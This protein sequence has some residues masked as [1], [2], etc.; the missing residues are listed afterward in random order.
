MRFAQVYYALGFWVVLGLIVFFIFALKDKKAT[1]QRFAQD[2]LLGEI[3]SSFDY[4]KQRLRL[5]LI[6]LVLIFSILALMRPQW[7]FQWQEVKRRGLDILIAIDTSKSMLASDVKPNRLE[8]S[9]LAVKDLIKKLQGDRIGLI[10]FSGTAFLQ[11]PLTVDYN[12]FLLALDDLGVDTI[13]QGGTSISWAVKEALKSFEGEEK[14]YK[15]LVIITDGEDHEGGAVR[16]AQAANKENVK[17]FSI[18]IGTS[19]GELIQVADARGSREFLKDKDGN[20]VKSRLNEG[21]LKQIA[22]TTGG[23][24]VRSSGAEFGLDLIY[25][26]KI[27]KMEKR[28]IK[29]QMAKFYHERFQIP[30]VIALLLLVA[31]IFITDKKKVV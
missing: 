14:K 21:V 1:M 8:R 29:A 7:G 24:Y 3:A 30:L 15:I 26:D 4:K 12:G 5:T 9:K 27:A 10:A 25:E 20:V 2:H 11:C 13:P 18:G 22:I 23:T 16:A 31:E 6:L 19:E 17:I 28:E